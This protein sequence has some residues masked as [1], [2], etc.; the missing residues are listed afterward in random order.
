M[1]RKIFIALVMLPMM[2]FAEEVQINGIWYNMIYKS[3]TAEVIKNPNNDWSDYSGNISIPETLNYNGENYTVNS[4]ARLAFCNP[5]GLKQLKSVS[6]PPTIKSIGYMAFDGSGI[7]DIYI[8][9]LESWCMISFDGDGANPLCHASYYY[10]HSNLIVNGKRVV[11]LIIPDGVTKIND[12]A[13]NGAGFKSIII[14]KSVVSIGKASFQ[15]CDSIFTIDIPEGTTTIGDFAF[16][17]CSNLKSVNIANTVKLIKLGA[18]WRCNNLKEITIGNGI[19]DIEGVAFGSCPQ[20]ENIYCYAQVPPNAKDNTF[21]NSMIEYSTLHVR[22]SS[23]GSYK[24]VSPWR[25]FKEIVKL[26]IPTYKLVYSIDG[27]EYKS[28]DVEEGLPITPE[29]VPSKVGYT[30]SGW[31]DIPTSMPANDVI[32]TG[33]FSIN[34]YKL[35]YVIDNTIYK[36]TTYEYG[37]TIIPEPQPE[38]DYATFEWV[39]LPQTMPAH[40]VVVKASYTT[41]INEVSTEQ[42]KGVHVFFIN[43]QQ[44]KKLQKGVNIIRTNNGKAKMVVVK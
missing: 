35:T 11:D 14:P 9:D 32:I 13:F 17:M 27:E 3:K 37:T 42:L 29:P 19:T 28:Y 34:R 41:S 22:G 38:G 10:N 6:I 7:C 31:S 24:L 12:Y 16:D 4:I 44:L 20:L 43:G 1:K 15:N 8:N 18:F 40:D 36:E 30:F 26:N 2:L 5:S 33:T 39:D 25:V 21:E 23:I